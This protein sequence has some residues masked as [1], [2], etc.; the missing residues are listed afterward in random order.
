MSTCP[1]LEDLLRIDSEAVADSTFTRLEQHLEACPRCRD[2]LQRQLDSDPDREETLLGPGPDAPPPGPPPV[3]GYR[4]DRELGRG[5]MGVVYL[6]SRESDGRPV[7]LKYLGGGPGDRAR[8]RREARSMAAVDH[9]GVVRL[10]EFVEAG[11]WTCLVLE[12]VPG[13]R[14][15]DRLDG[16]PSPRHAAELVEAVARAIHQVHLAGLLHLDLKPSNILLEGGPEVALPMARPRVADF[17][18]ALPWG[19]ADASWTLAA[20]PRGTPSYMAPEQLSPTRATIGPAADVYAL[21]ALLYRMLAG[22]PPFLAGSKVETYIQLRDHDPVPPRRLNPRVPAALETICLAC[23]RKDPTRRYATA[24]DLADDLR[25]VLDGLPIRMRATPA[26]VRVARWGRRNP[27]LA[28]SLAAVLLLSAFAFALLLERAR[29]ARLDADRAEARRL[30]DTR[31]ARLDADR[32]EARRLADARNGELATQ[33]AVLGFQDFSQNLL[34]SPDLIAANAALTESMIGLE[35]RFE[36]C[37][38]DGMI[39]DANLRLQGILQREIARRLHSTGDPIAAISE[40]SRARNTF[41]SLLRVHPDD[42]AIRSQLAVTLNDI[43]VMRTLNFAD[44]VDEA[45]DLFRESRHHAALLHEATAQLLDPDSQI[46]MRIDLADHLRRLGQ[47]ERARELVAENCWF[48]DRLPDDRPVN[49]YLTAALASTASWL[50]DQDESDRLAA[51]AVRQVAEGRVDDLR[52]TFA[53]R[54]WFLRPAGPLGPIIDD[55]RERPR[56]K[57]ADDWAG[58]IEDAIRD[59]LGRIGIGGP[60]PPALRSAIAR[61]H[62]DLLFRMGVDLRR[63][64]RLADSRQV[65]GVQMVLGNW[66]VHR[67]PDDAEAHSLLRQANQQV[68][69]IHIEHSKRDDDRVV[70]HISQVVRFLRHA[71]GPAR[72]AAELEPTSTTHLRDLQRIEQDIRDWEERLANLTAAPES[73]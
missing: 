41:E 12:Y 2:A 11:P 37:R 26:P 5:G 34:F 64:G 16:S 49:A 60:T 65:A 31:G 62:V 68:A 42:L 7:A 73:E 8:W 1:S 4:V 13:G 23:L 54:S 22:R 69:K 6:A 35:S 10:L 30:A 55:L 28:T 24:E 33:A 45:I 53:L 39:N 3:P 19:D 63:L 46:T 21:G 36:T 9:P 67:D 59:D 38:L 50:G 71:E 57:D 52:G 14:L 40:W 58:A 72:R 56:S 51:E 18:L 66:F 29:E 70:E 17:G 15:E 43:A 61:W 32:A 47:P 48:I 27:A 25:R 44:D 20:G